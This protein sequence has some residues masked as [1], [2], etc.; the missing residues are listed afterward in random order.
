MKDIK[1]EKTSSQNITTDDRMLNAFVKWYE[2][3]MVHRG[4]VLRI[5]N[6]Q[7]IRYADIMSVFG[8][9]HIVKASMVK[10]INYNNIKALFAGNEE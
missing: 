5:F 3:G 1:A 8:R 10:L 4:T 6:R 2:G 7:G 9:R